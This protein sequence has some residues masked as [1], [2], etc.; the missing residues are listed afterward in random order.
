MRPRGSIR[1]ELVK[2]QSRILGLLSFGVEAFPAQSAWKSRSQGKRVVS[3]LP[4]VGA[5]FDLTGS[6]RTQAPGI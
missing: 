4:S 6:V 3:N 2:Q 5:K 1:T